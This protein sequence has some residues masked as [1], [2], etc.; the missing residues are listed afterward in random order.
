MSD[1]R[2]S[3]EA[4]GRVTTEGN[5]SRRH[6]ARSRGASRG[7]TRK[8]RESRS[9]RGTTKKRR[10]RS[11][12]RE[13][14]SHKR[15]RGRGLINIPEEMTRLMKFC[16]GFRVQKGHNMNM[17]DIDGLGILL[18]LV[19]IHVIDILVTT[20]LLGVQDFP[21]ILDHIMI[22]RSTQIVMGRLL[23]FRNR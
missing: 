12:S 23:Q 20:L 4:G 3:Q 14:E 8:R 5:L 13:P 21:L 10:S 11:G 2:E 18:T 7:R 19:M 1:N 16:N 15:S 9:R 6:R 22:S 17:K